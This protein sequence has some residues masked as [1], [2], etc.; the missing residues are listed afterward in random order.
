M[1]VDLFD[2]ELPPELIAQKP[3]TPRDSSRLLVIGPGDGMADRGV[4]DLPD[5]LRPGDVMVV[6]DTKVIPARLSGVRGD[7]RDRGRPGGGARVE[8]TLHKWFENGAWAAFA[9]PARKLLPG[10]FVSFAPGFG[11]NVGARNGGEVI[12]RFTLFG[13]DLQAA[14]E[15]HGRMPLPPYIKRDGAVDEDER[16]RKDYQTAFAARDG[17]VAAPTASLHFTDQ[18][19]AAIEARGVKRATVTLHVGAGTFLP[20]KTGDTKDHVMHSEWGEVTP[21]TARVVNDARAAGGRVLAC[22]STAARLLESAAE[23]DGAVRPFRGETDI[24]ITPGYRFKIC[25]LMLT[26]FHLPKSTLMM[27][28]SAFSGLDAIKS[29]YR[30]AVGERYRFFS[31]GDACLLH[32]NDGIMRAL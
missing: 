5:F 10:D 19:L 28:V 14:L 31:Y 11:A 6:N 32:R 24:F 29:A 12:L 2:F 13:P 30:H 9:R 20:V 26:N 22:G 27:L 7:A 3:A 15:K 21:E 1:D 25:D 16:D 23:E 8:V 17:A 4:L 18:L